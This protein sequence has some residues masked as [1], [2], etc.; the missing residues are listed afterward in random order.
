ME[1]NKRPSI[2]TEEGNPFIKR[3]N[4]EKRYA[5]AVWPI[6]E[7]RTSENERELVSA[8]DTGVGDAL[9]TIAFKIHDAQEKERYYRR[10]LLKS[11]EEVREEFKAELEALQNKLDR[12]RMRLSEKEYEA[13]HNFITK[14]YK[15]H[16]DGKYKRDEGVTVH[17]VGTG[18]GCCYTL[19]CPVC[20]ETE[21]ST[22]V[23]SW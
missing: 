12:A 2:L 20:H 14:H 21:D 23:S 8:F 9:A 6:P 7:L 22:D 15:L 16:N 4:Q 13:Y 19:E 10:E 3:A 18:L 1:E 5:A 17:I 11:R